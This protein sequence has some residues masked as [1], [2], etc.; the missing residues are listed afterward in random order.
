MFI[1]ELTSGNV[2]H[3]I[4]P[5]DVAGYLIVGKRVGS[6][7]GSPGLRHAISGDFLQPN[8]SRLESNFG[9]FGRR[10]QPRRMEWCF[11]LGDE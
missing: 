2:S 8:I 4:N 7:S 3:L 10:V 9:P 6:Y 11:K 1:G 5:D